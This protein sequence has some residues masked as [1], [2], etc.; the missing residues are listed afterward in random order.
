G[1]REIL[2]SL[3]GGDVVYGQDQRAGLV[4]LNVRQ[5]PARDHE[6]LGARHLDLEPVTIASSWPVATCQASRQPPPPN[7][8]LGSVQACFG[9]ATGRA[10]SPRSGRTAPAPPDVHGARC[11]AKAAPT[12]HLDTADRRSNRQALIVAARRRALAPGAGRDA[13]ATPGSSAD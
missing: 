11:K 3:D 6:R 2:G 9:R 4:G 7:R 13:T 8:V 1:L 12:G 5:H 10:A